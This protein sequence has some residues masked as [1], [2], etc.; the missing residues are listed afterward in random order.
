MSEETLA[1]RELFIETISNARGKTNEKINT[2][3]PDRVERLKECYMKIQ[4]ILPENFVGFVLPD[5]DYYTERLIRLERD[6]VRIYHRKTG[7][8]IKFTTIP[9]Y[10]DEI[11]GKI[12]DVELRCEFLD[13]AYETLL[14]WE[15]AFKRVKMNNIVFNAL[16]VYTQ[17]KKSP[18]EAELTE[19]CNQMYGETFATKD[20][21]DALNEL[22]R[23]NL[24]GI[25]SIIPKNKYELISKKRTV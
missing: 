24:V 4:K 21:S 18:T 1:E 7:E 14:M 19:S 9:E 10:F 20:V 3:I 25:S 2:A 8:D 13:S 12:E 6:K 16:S 15:G 17:Q 22:K 23:L 5:Y 11:L